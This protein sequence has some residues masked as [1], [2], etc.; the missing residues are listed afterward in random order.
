MVSEPNT[1]AT[2]AATTS[3]SNTSTPSTS[4]S[5]VPSQSPLLLLSNMANLMSAKLD[6]N[7]YI[8]EKLVAFLEAYSLI[9]HIDGSVSQPCPFLLDS[10]GNLTTYCCESRVSDMENQR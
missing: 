9:E 8:P 3:T 7:N 6:Y 10:Q 5:V 1:M 4:H 2:A